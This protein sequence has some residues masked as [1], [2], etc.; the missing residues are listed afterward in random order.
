[1]R[2]APGATIPQYSPAT[3]K[4]GATP[5][6]TASHLAVLVGA[7]PASAC[8]G[9]GAAARV[10]QARKG[11]ST[12]RVQACGRFGPIAQL[13]HCTH[14]H[15]PRGDNRTP[16]LKSDPPADLPPAPHAVY[17]GIGVCCGFANWGIDLQGSRSSRCIVG[18]VR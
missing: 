7:A 4:K 14:P 15:T 9:A 3:G 12:P 10:Q 2:C 1:M 11:V 13:L 17:I 6:A 18:R 5:A 16:N 8:L